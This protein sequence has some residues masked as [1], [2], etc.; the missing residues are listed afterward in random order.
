MLIVFFPCITKNRIE[1]HIVA[2]ALHETVTLYLIFC[3]TI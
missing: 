3:D 2:A 1:R